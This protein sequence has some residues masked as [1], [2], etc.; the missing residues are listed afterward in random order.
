MKTCSHETPQVHGLAPHLHLS[1]FACREVEPVFIASRCNQDP[2]VVPSVPGT[3]RSSA[4]RP[5]TATEVSEENVVEVNGS[6]C[7]W[8]FSL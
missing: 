8:A 1:A 2:A 6:S 4:L 3:G 7:C 5:W